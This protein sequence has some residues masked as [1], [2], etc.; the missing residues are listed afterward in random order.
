MAFFVQVAKKIRVILP[1]SVV[2]F[3][4]I[5]GIDCN[6]SIDCRIEQTSINSPFCDVSLPAILWVLSL[7]WVGMF[8][9][10]FNKKK[11]INLWVILIPTVILATLTFAIFLNHRI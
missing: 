2:S 11:R 10:F 8:G 6:L 9:W 5:L 7:A 1:L 4:F 3:P